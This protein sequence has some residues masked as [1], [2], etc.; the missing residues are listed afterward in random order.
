MRSGKERK[1][2]ATTTYQHILISDA[3]NTRRRVERVLCCCFGEDFLARLCECVFTW[4]RETGVS[5]K[6]LGVHDDDDDDGESV[7]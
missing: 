7:R 5:Y 1:T 4:G 2:S 6:P 3:V